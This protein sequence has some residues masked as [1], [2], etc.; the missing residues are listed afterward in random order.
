MSGSTR[1][2]GP[3][4]HYASRDQCDRAAVDEHQYRTVTVR[5]GPWPSARFSPAPT[6]AGAGPA[7]AATSSPARAGSAATRVRRWAGST[8]PST[9]GAERVGASESRGDDDGHEPL[10][11]R[12][13]DGRDGVPCV[14]DGQ[15]PL[16]HDVAH[17]R[18]LPG[19]RGSRGVSSS[20][21]R[22]TWTGSCVRSR[23]GSRR[24][25]ARVRAPPPPA[26]PRPPPCRPS[27][28]RA[29]PPRARACAPPAATRGRGCARTG[30]SRP[31]RRRSGHTSS[32]VAGAGSARCSPRSTGCRR[33]RST[34]RSPGRRRRR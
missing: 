18:A 29:A 1:R 33:R 14:R 34:P 3:L 20:R 5:V 24:P 4:F 26:A 8:T 2:G 25:R 28:R 23:A 13:E 12:I 11:V 19:R 27:R 31:G 16:R 9:S 7:C 32:P 6:A 15:A 22:S 30:R 10:G 21:R 17:E